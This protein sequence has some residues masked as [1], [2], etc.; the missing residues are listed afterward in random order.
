MVALQHYFLTQA[1]PGKRVV[2]VLDEH[3]GIEPGAINL[4]HAGLIVRLPVRADLAVST[5]GFSEFPRELQR[6]VEQADY[7][8]AGRL[9]LTGQLTTAFPD[10]RFVNQGDVVGAAM[11]QFTRIGV[12]RFH[13]GDN[14]LLCG[15]RPTKCCA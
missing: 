14:Y 10:I 3:A 4:V 12:E 13:I 6:R 8:G 5:F 15:E 2:A 9:F 1:L 11:Q 7:F